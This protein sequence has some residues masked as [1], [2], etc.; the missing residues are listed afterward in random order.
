LKIIAPEVV[1]FF[2]PPFKDRKNHIV[3]HQVYEAL[4]LGDTMA[5][6]KQGFMATV[7]ITPA[8][9]TEERPEMERRRH[10]S[11]RVTKARKAKACMTV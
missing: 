1:R 4:E 5:F 8:G 3:N 10:F 6:E 2:I 9:R 7:T 11:R